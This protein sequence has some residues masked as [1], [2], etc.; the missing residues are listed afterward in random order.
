MQSTN[1]TWLSQALWD[2]VLGVA[3]YWDLI[4]ANAGSFCVAGLHRQCSEVSRDPDTGGYRHLPREPPPAL[5]GQTEPSP[6]SWEV[7]SPST[8]YSRAGNAQSLEKQK[9]FTWSWNH[10]LTLPFRKWLWFCHI[11]SCSQEGKREGPWVQKWA[12]FSCWTHRAL[13]PCTHN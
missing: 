2:S 7:W 13:C 12:R 8:S 3:S 1:Y 10:L 5:A 6:S 9:R 4:H 11:L